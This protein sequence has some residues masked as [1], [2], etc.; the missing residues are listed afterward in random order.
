MKSIIIALSIVVF[1]S[2]A[3]AYDGWGQG[4]ITRMRVQGGRILVNQENMINPGNCPNGDY[5]HL[6]ASDTSFD[7]NRYATLL[8]AYV[9]G[10]EVWL[11]LNGC[12]GGYPFISEIWVR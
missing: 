4:K 1:F 10:K 12:S 3:Y 5:Y 7:R 11:A 2:V 6:D 9:T 8:T